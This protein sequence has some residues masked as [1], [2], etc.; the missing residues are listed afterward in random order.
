MPV[1]FTCRLLVVRTESGKLRVKYGPSTT[2]MASRTRGPNKKTP[3]RGAGLVQ[4]ASLAEL[5]FDP[6]DALADSFADARFP[7]RASYPSA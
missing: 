2:K 6:L 1:R 4:L 7:G 5:G 3:P